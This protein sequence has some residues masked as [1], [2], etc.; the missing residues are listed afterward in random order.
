MIHWLYFS[1]NRGKIYHAKNV[2]A[3]RKCLS[4]LTKCL[5]WFCDNCTVKVLESP[6]EKRYWLLTVNFTLALAF[7]PSHT[8]IIKDMIYLNIF[9][10]ISRV[11]ICKLY[12]WFSSSCGYFLEALILLTVHWQA[13]RINST[14]PRERFTACSPQWRTIKDYHFIL[15]AYISSAWQHIHNVYNLHKNHKCCIGIVCKS[16]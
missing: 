9:N 6:R 10:R 1:H 8:I 4:Y 5:N 14:E 13:E 12:V 15:L 3:H 11:C 2:K 7:K 16:E